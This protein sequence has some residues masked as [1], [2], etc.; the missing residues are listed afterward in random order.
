MLAV[1]AATAVGAMASTA[2]TTAVTH[3][4]S[5]LIFGCMVFPPNF[6]N[7]SLAFLA[8]NPNYSKED[9]K[10]MRYIQTKFAQAYSESNEDANAVITSIGSNTLPR[11]AINS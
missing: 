5:G 4:V 3:A 8:F 7:R 2:A 6:T 10:R 11:P 9:R 1:G